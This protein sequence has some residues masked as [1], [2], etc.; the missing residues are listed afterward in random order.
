M[1][2]LHDWHILTSWAPINWNTVVAGPRAQITHIFPTYKHMHLQSLFL[3][4]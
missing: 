3:Q 4:T 2:R 1:W